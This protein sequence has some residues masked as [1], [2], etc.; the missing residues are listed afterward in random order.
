MI[1]EKEVT[2]S[3]GTHLTQHLKSN[4]PFSKEGEGRTEVWA[5]NEPSCVEALERFY[6]GQVGGPFAPDLLTDHMSPKLPSY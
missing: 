4:V 6:L 1:R 2:P 5:G 3:F